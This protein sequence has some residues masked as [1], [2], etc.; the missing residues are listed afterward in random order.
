MKAYYQLTSIKSQTA[1]IR[2]DGIKLSHQVIEKFTLYLYSCEAEKIFCWLSIQIAM[3][4]RTMHRVVVE[5]V[6]IVSIFV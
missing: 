3:G 6:D 5:V 1:I 4:V 2:F